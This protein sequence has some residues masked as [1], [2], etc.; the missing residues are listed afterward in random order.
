MTPPPRPRRVQLFPVL[1]G[2]V[3]LVVAVLYLLQAGG[4][5][6]LSNWMVLPVEAAGLIVAGL[7]AAAYS[8]RPRRDASQESTER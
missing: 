7:L 3:F 1:G 4:A 5:F 8:R 6:R 2:L